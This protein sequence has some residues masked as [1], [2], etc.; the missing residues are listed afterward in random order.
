MR[1]A[2]NVWGDSVGTGTVEA[3][4]KKDLARLDEE[5]DD[6]GMKDVE[7]PPPAYNGYMIS[8]TFIFST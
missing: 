1:T 6:I 8:N 7:Q 3:S 4:V 2:V 5:G